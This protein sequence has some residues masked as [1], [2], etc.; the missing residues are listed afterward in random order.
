MRTAII[1]AAMIVVVSLFFA[2]RVQAEGPCG[3]ENWADWE[4]LGPISLVRDTTQRP[5]EWRFEW[6]VPSSFTVSEYRVNYG[7]LGVRPWRQYNSPPESTGFAEDGTPNPFWVLSFPPHDLLGFVVMATQAGTTNTHCASTSFFAPWLSTVDVESRTA[8]ATAA[9]QFWSDV[10]D[11]S[12][13]IGELEDERLSL[14]SRIEKL[15]QRV[16][17][18]ERALDRIPSTREVQLRVQLGDGL[19]RIQHS[20]DGGFLWRTATEGVVY[21]HE[22]VEAGAFLAEG[23]PGR[24]EVP[25]GKK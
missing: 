18:L 14:Y 23:P 11:Y 19:Y 2:A 6:T 24:I 17:E 13:R 16:L 25:T 10:N 4:D 9:P 20:L 15:N 5:V 12:R 7:A 21:W 22:H 8:L 1:S 3:V